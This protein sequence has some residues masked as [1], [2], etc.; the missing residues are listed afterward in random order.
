M[1]HA[2]LTVPV[3]VIAAG[4][5][6]RYH[7][8]PLWRQLLDIPTVL[9]NIRDIFFIIIG[10]VQSLLLLIK[11]KPD[12][13]FAKGGYVCLPLGY[14]AKLLSVPLVIHDSDARP[15][16]TNKLLSRYAT[17][18]ATGS[19][20]E[21]YPYPPDRS[22]YTGVPIAAAF[23]PFD[24]DEQQRAKHVL[25]LADLERPLIVVTGGGLGAESI[26]TGVNL[27]AQDLIDAGF[28]VYHVTGKR[29]YKQ[30][31]KARYDHP[32]YHIVEF[33][34]KD[35]ATVLGA[36]DIVISRGSATFLQE[37][38]ALAKPTIIV[39]ASHLGDQVKNAVVYEQAKAAIVLTDDEVRTGKVLF[40]AITT[41][42]TN[43]PDSNAMAKRFFAFAKP[44]A[45]KDVANIV[46][47]TGKQGRA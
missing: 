32:D 16:L 31:M 36:A 42:H 15:G 2:P 43:T 1:Q 14:A 7:G 45:A 20:L 18:I 22:V 35:M 26:N 10:F 13:V 39:P 46:L 34:Y 29:H 12:V 3:H 21:N 23:H 27:I 11:E 41:L 4:K 24:T 47:E 44:D 37:L 8:V 25:G 19:P 38:A 17:S 30:I 9:K 5:L 6:R 28:S 40:D 33:V